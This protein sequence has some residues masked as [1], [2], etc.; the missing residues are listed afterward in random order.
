MKPGLHQP[1]KLSIKP[2]F[3]QNKAV[4]CLQEDEETEIS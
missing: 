4:K 1:N 3:D 2:L